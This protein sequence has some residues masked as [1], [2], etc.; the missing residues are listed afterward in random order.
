MGLGGSTH[1]CIHFALH[2]HAVA[3]RVLMMMRH[4]AHLERVDALALLAVRG[5]ARY[6]PMINA[7]IDLQI[8][9]RSH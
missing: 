3:H 8:N 2:A 6:L 7:Q 5:D 9:G 1:R 4:V